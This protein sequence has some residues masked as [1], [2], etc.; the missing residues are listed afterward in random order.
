M[1]KRLPICFSPL[2]DFRSL[3]TLPLTV[4]LSSH[5]FGGEES[6][7]SS[8]AGREPL[9]SASEASA[10]ARVEQGGRVLAPRP[11]SALCHLARCPGPSS[12]GRSMQ[13]ATAAAL[14]RAQLGLRCR[15]LLQVSPVPVSRGPHLH[16]KEGPRPMGQCGVTDF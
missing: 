2:A 4:V 7:Q 10:E 11:L 5:V 6:R 3:R 8:P 12:A 16:H 9:A 13:A 1:N 14:A 15:S